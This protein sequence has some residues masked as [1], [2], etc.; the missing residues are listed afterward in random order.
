LKIR[1]LLCEYARQ[2]NLT[3]FESLPSPTPKNVTDRYRVGKVAFDNE[4]GMGSTPNNANASYLGFTIFISPDEFLRFAAPGQRRE[5]SKKLYLEI[6][7]H[8]PIGT[9]FLAIKYN[10]KQF[11]QGEPLRVEVVGHE[12]RNRCGAIEMLNGAHEKMPVHI[13]PRGEL[14][15]RHFNEH[16]FSELRVRGMVPEGSGDGAEPKKMDISKIFWMGKQ[17]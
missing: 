11:G 2:L 9:P 12:G 13:I 5:Q 6:K 14:R 3:E 16:F 7:N 8:V 1:E 4:S 10:E 17:L 15:A